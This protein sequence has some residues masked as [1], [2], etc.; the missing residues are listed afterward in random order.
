VAIDLPSAQ[1]R[2]PFDEY[3][4]WPTMR[5]VRSRAPFCRDLHR[6]AEGQSRQA[7]PAT[8]RAAP[9]RVCTRSL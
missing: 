5:Y 2:L 9:T 7:S 3:K 8:V 6:V 1:T 4:H